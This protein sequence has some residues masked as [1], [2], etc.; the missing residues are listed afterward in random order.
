MSDIISINGNANSALASLVQ[1]TNNAANSISRL[2]SGNKFVGAGEGVAERSVASA[3]YS[4]L[5]AA[6]IAKHNSTQATSLLESSDSIMRGSYKILERQREL[7]MQAASDTMSDRE[8]V[9]LNIEYRSGF[10]QINSNANFELNS[11]KLL[12]GSYSGVSTLSTYQGEKVVYDI[13][14]I[15]QIIPHGSFGKNEVFAKG[16]RIESS[17]NMGKASASGKFDLTDIAAGDVI[18]INGDAFTAVSNVTNNNNQFLVGANVSDT[19]V[20]LAETLINSDM[21]EITKSSYQANGTNLDIQ[22]NQTGFAG[23]DFM[24]DIRIAATTGLKGTFNLN[25]GEDMRSHSSVVI[26]LDNT[27]NYAAD[28]TIALGDK[29]FTFK[30]TAADIV[31]DSDIV[32]GTDLAGTM[33]NLITAVN[34]DPTSKASLKYD[35]SN[36]Y[37]TITY[38]EAGV[39]G[40]NYSFALDGT[41]VKYNLE[42]GG[43]PTVA[44][45]NTYTIEGVASGLDLTAG[46]EALNGTKISTDE[47]TFDNNMYGKFDNFNITFKEGKMNS[48]TDFTENK[49]QFSILL[50]NELYQSS[51]IALAGGQAVGGNGYNG[52]GNKI[53]SGSEI[54][55]QKADSKST[56]AG[57]KM[58]ISDK[59]VNIDGRS[60]SD[61]HK[62]LASYSQDVDEAI[63]LGDINL[64][65]VGA[66]HVVNDVGLYDADQLSTTGVLGAGSHLTGEIKISDAVGKNDAQGTITLKA[67]PVAADYIVINGTQVTF[68]QDVTIGTDATAT[69][70]NLIN[71]LNSSTDTNISKAIYY[72][73]GVDTVIVKSK[74]AG[75]VGNN[76]TLASSDIS[77]FYLN[78]VPVASTSLGAIQ[79]TG[80]TKASGT[81][82]LPNNVT[83]AASGDA[84]LTIN[85]TD[86]KVDGDSNCSAGSNNACLTG[87]S[88]K[89]SVATELTRAINTQTSTT[90]VVATANGDNVD[91]E[92]DSTGP[93]GNVAVTWTN[94]N[95]LT[96]GSNPINLTVPATLS[97]GS[98]GMNSSKNVIHGSDFPHDDSTVIP[99]DLQGKISNLQAI[100]HEGTVNTDGLKPNYVS[101][102][103]KFGDNIYSGKLA[104]SGGNSTGGRPSGSNYNKLGDKISAGS[105][106]SLHAEDRSTAIELTVDNNGIDLSGM[107]KAEVTKKLNKAFAQMESGLADIAIQQSRVIA[108]VDE[109][110]AVGTM[111]DGVK[112]DNTHITGSDFQKDGKFGSISSFKVDSENNKLSVKINDTEYSQ[113]LSDKESIGGLGDRYDSAHKVILGGMDT[114]ITLKNKSGEALSINLQG[115]RDIDVMNRALDFENALNTVFGSNSSSGLSFQVGTRIEDAVTLTFQDIGGDALY[116]D[117]NGNVNTNTNIATK[118]SALEAFSTIESALF[119]LRSQIANNGSAVNKLKNVEN[120]INAVIESL[121]DAHADLIY[122]S[123]PEAVA[124]QAA[125]SVKATASANAFVM[126]N[127][128]L[129]DIIGTIVRA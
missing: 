40:N 56:D 23:N 94:N 87:K 68:Q 25:G 13:D 7:T 83:A 104:L 91:L 1:Y 26:E 37:L 119:Y 62:L 3:L 11:M 86:I 20:N 110:A 90:H 10:D 122:I 42:Q 14:D 120:N 103:A 49:V 6:K 102:S 12:N 117:A 31:L 93:A 74:E 41:T 45:K 59:G 109:K 17:D 5:S 82:T 84:K 18:T 113:V 73:S 71:Y 69:R 78:D 38:K 21:P 64:G 125:N 67:Q 47:P 129:R 98:N 24:I 50:N 65:V 32:F 111:L 128:L 33:N 36:G 39:T 46:A 80:P 28:E 34:K 72:S 16:S 51:D 127:N 100:F 70:N 96:D 22:Y 107:T 4:T 121:S 53:T 27:T 29:T 9:A 60:L 126:N 48:P 75:S 55:F 105:T 15:S 88:T 66:S 85:A 19:V 101:I 79:N 63:K 99:N 124:E 95:S 35:N 54:L 116:K 106:I 112:K 43:T 8:R 77:K 114:T 81:I 97:G 123:T 118:D 58:K 92:Y 52:F 44:T 115:V 108:N 89:A 61:I 76:F 30:A 57:L 2:A